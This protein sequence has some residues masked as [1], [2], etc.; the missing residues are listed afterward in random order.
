MKK[1]TVETTE[2]RVNAGIKVDDRFYVISLK[3][4]RRE[5]T[6]NAVTQS[7]Y[8]SNGIKQ[9]IVNVKATNEETG[10]TTIFDL[11]KLI[12]FNATFIR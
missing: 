5:Y 6:V 2:T 10:K 11:Q 4:E 12:C 8:H 3:N 9:T 1:T 7:N